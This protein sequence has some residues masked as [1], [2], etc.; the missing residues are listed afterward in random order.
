MT[1]GADFYAGGVVG[2]VSDGGTSSGR[3]VKVT[4]TDSIID[5]TF[6][7]TKGTQKIALGGIVGYG[8]TSAYNYEAEQ[9][10][11]TE[12]NIVVTGCDIRLKITGTAT[13]ANLS[14]DYGVGAYIG[15]MGNGKTDAN[16]NTT[17]VKLQNNHVNVTSATL[18]I[19]PI[20]G[21]ENKGSG[22]FAIPVASDATCTYTGAVTVNENAEET[23]KNEAVTAKSAALYTYRE[24]LFTYAKNVVDKTLNE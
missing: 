16:T 1:T 23:V 15:K 2:V 10:V 9:I 7:I 11:T 22:T 5:V 14:S 21:K 6:N 4:V 18:E 24:D 3:D 13:K 20:Y 12:N 8:A 19:A 17:N